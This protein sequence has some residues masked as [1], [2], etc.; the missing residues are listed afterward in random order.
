MTKYQILKQFEK[1][2]MH[3]EDIVTSGETTNITLLN[4]GKKL[5]GDRFIGVFSANE[6][7]NYVRNSE[8]FIINTDPSNKPGMHWIS[9][10]KYNKKFFGFDSYG[11]RIQTLSKYWK[12]KRN[13]IN[14]NKERDEPFNGSNCGALS[15]AYLVIFDKYHDKCIG[16]V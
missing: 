5:F 11:R 14:A 3:I 13:I 12:N 7:P 4:V 16:V 6:F 2:L 1:S 15:L 10:Y 8:M 9:I